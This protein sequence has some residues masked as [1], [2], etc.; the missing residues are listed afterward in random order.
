M[1]FLKNLGRLERENSIEK[2]NLICKIDTYIWLSG[3]EIYVS[4]PIK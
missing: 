3:S 4:T 1:P 2:C